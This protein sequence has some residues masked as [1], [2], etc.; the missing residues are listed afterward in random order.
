MLRNSRRP[1][2]ANPNP[3]LRE[4]TAAWWQG[5]LPG[6]MLLRVTASDPAWQEAAWDGS[7]DPLVRERDPRWHAHQ[8]RRELH[9]VHWLEDGVPR[10][11]PVIASHL[12]WLAGFYGASWQYESGSAWAAPMPDILDRRPE[13]FTPDHPLVRVMEGALRAQAA[14]AAGVGFVAPPALLD[15]LTAL[16]QLLGGEALCDA[17]LQEPERIEAWL[18][19]YETLLLT[20][21]RWCQETVE[22]LGFGEGSSWLPLCAPGRFEAVQCDAAVLL[23]PKMFQR[24]VLPSLKRQV[25][26]LDFALYHHDGVEQTRFHDLLAT[27]PGL[28]GI[29]WNPQPASNAI[30]DPRWIEV[31]RRIRARGWVLHFNPFECRNVD[32]VEAVIRAVGPE[33]LSFTLPTFTSRTEADE[34]IR[35]LRAAENEHAARAA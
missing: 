15:G 30:E 6:R 13:P 23:S 24:F 29:Q 17:L 28:N 20:A 12:Y 4:R 10:T 21:Q 26:T 8:A 9:S 27:I 7:P 33:G 1:F 22:S 5:R 16:S 3:T 34:A 35:R 14:E 31:F 25:A 11:C 19:G 18:A 32:V 2:S